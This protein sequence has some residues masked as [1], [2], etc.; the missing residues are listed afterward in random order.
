M[1]C[2]AL[3]GKPQASP[4][5]NVEVIALVKAK[6]AEIERKVAV[7]LHEVDVLVGAHFHLSRSLLEI[8]R[9]ARVATHAASSRNQRRHQ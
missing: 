9:R 6:L 4:G 8:E 2:N 7:R 1:S 5:H 3:R